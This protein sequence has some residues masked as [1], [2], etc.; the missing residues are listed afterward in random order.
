[1]INPI[2]IFSRKLPDGF[3][4]VKSPCE[5]LSPHSKKVAE[6]FRLVGIQREVF[7]RYYQPAINQLAAFAQA[8]PASENHH[9]AYA[10]GLLEHSLQTIQFALKARKSHILPAGKGPEITTRYSDLYTYCVF[11]A[12]ILHDIAKPATDQRITLFASTKDMIGEWSPFKVNMQESGAKFY[13]VTYR[14][15]RQYRHHEMAS[16]MFTRIIPDCGL[17]WLRSE[18]SVFNELL[19]TAANLDEVSVVKEIVKKGDQA[20]VSLNLGAQTLPAFS[21][22]KPLHE[23]I[24]T[25]LRKLASDGEITFNRKGANAFVQN[26]KCWVMAKT[27]PDLVRKQLQDEGHTGIPTGNPRLFDVMTEHK[28]IQPNNDDK[29]VWKI[30]IAL[31]DWYPDPF[32]MLCLPISILFT[33]EEAVPDSF[34]GNINIISDAEKVPTE[35]TPDPVSIIKTP[36]TESASTT[37]SSEQSSSSLLSLFLDDDPEEKPEIPETVVPEVETTST[38]VAEDHQTIKDDKI[39]ATTS[40]TV[41]N[42]FKEWL[43]SGLNHKSMQTNTSD[44]MVHILKEGLFLVSPAIFKEY[45]KQSGANWQ[46]AQREFQREKLQLK[47]EN[48]ENWFEVRIQGRKGYSTLK[49]WIVPPEKLQIAAKSLKE[50]NNHLKLTTK[51]MQI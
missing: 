31:D 25:A 39:I 11:C 21:N 8:T 16:L 12:A 42:S 3:Y 46:D 13:T 29:A 17:D 7:D 51:Q 49:G 43:V 41:S 15:D 24:V 48:E 18:P 22:T 20:S 9:H 36:P 44:A 26:G 19:V 38:P 14:R 33:S 2:S 28:I 30:Q 6:I 47:N 37:T 35:A 40:E 5:L 1:M 50:P 45:G 32:T 27:L 34:P 10:G 4:R 23:K